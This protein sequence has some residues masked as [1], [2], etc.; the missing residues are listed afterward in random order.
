MNI[1]HLDKPGKIEVP[2]G[3]SRY[4]IRQNEPGE[5]SYVFHLRQ[6]DCQT[7][8]LAL[9]ETAGESALL[10]KIDVIHH[11]PAT[12]S[13]TLVKTLACDASHPRFEGLIRVEPAAR[14]SESRLEHHSLLVG[15]QAKSRTLPSLEILTDDVKCSH[16]ATVRTLSE[17]DLF[18]PRSRGIGVPETRNMLIEA[19]L[20]DVAECRSQ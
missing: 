10:L 8:I 6:P 13:K 7:Q 4:L 2:T 14:G 12:R 17:L 18:Y 9:V 20:A 5:Q 11:A 15:D 3:E 19:F 16:A 1:F